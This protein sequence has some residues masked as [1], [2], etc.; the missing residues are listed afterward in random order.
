MAPTAGS[1]LGH[2]DVAVMVGDITHSTIA[3]M[4][5]RI[6]NG[7][8]A[9]G[10]DRGPE[11]GVAGMR[12]APGTRLGA[13][14]VTASIGERDKGDDAE[15]SGEVFGASSRDS[16]LQVFNQSPCVG[17]DVSWSQAHS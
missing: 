7:T 16:I 17:C 13:Y 11:G 10:G 8:L 3:N 4:V 9:P 15:C 1:G 12:L 2:D 5:A 6:R 14:A